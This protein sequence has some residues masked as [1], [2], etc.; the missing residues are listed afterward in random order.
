MRRVGTTNC[1]LW[2]AMGSWPKRR[3]AAPAGRAEHARKRV[4]GEAD[5]EENDGEEEGMGKVTNSTLATRQ[6]TTVV[7]FWLRRGL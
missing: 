3:A 2:S 7:S 5:G 1:S 6:W 4:E